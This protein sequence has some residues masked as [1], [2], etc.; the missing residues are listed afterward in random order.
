MGKYGQQLGEMKTK[1]CIQ[2]P[3]WN[4]MKGNVEQLLRAACPALEEEESECGADRH[5][6]VYSH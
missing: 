6:E 5:P 2:M 3:T 4:K 1:S